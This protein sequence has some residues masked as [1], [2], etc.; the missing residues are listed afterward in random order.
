MATHGVFPKFFTALVC[1]IILISPN[2]TL[3]RSGSEQMDS[4]WCC[5]NNRAFSSSAVECEERGGTFFDLRRDADQACRSRRTRQ[6]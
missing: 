6:G 3:A 1:A 2:I 5:L 4:G